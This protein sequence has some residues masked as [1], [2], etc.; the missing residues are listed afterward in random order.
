MKEDFNQIFRT[1][2]D[3]GKRLLM[4]N[5]RIPAFVL[6]V[7]FSQLMVLSVL[8]QVDESRTVKGKIT[9]NAGEPLPGVTVIVPE[10]TIGAVSDA[11]GI[12]L[13][14]VPSTTTQLAF[15]FIGMKTQIIN[16]T[17]QS[18][19]NV[20]MLDESIGLDEVVAVGYGTVSRKNL[21]TAISKV[22]TDEIVK[23][24]NSNMSQLLVGRASGLQATIQSAQPGGNVNLS[25]RGAGTPIYIVDGVMMP[26]GSLESGS[27]G[28]TTVI[29]SSVNRSGLAGLNPEDIESVEILKDASASIYGIGAAN[30]VILITTKKGKEG[31]LKVNYNG[32]F[33]RVE[34]AKYVHPLNAQDYMNFVNT[35]SKEQYL[36]NNAMAPYGSKVYDNKWNPAF[37]DSE[38]ANAQTTDW[39]NEVLRS[40]SIS[41]HNI[42]VTGGGEK[43]KY[44]TSGN[45][46]KQIGTVSNSQ[47]ERYSLRSQIDFQ[48]NSFINL[49][50]TVNVNRNFYLNSS[51]GGTSNG[52]GAQAS[53]AL[54][55]ALSY[56][57]Y[58]PV[59]N[60]NGEY[61]SFSYI[62]NA[63]A[64]EEIEDY[65]NSDG[66]YMN[67]VADFNLIKNVLKAKLLYGNNLENTKRSVYIPSYVYFDQMYKSRGNLAE[68]SRLNQTLE[69]TLAFNKSFKDFLT[70]NIVAGVGKYF[71]SGD[72]LNVAYDGQ[73]DAIAN[74]NL[75]AATGVKTPGSYRY[76]DEKRSQFIRADFDILD[77]YV[78]G[79]TVRRDGTDKFFPDSK[80]AI[81]PSI[82]F[83]WK[84]S[85]ESFLKNVAWIDLLKIRA[86][87]GTTGSDNLGTTLYGTY[88]PSSSQVM[89]NNNTIKY[90]PIVLNGLD[91]PD[92]SWQK[93]T[94]NNI[95]IDF[96]LFNNRVYG[97]FDLFQND[98]TDMLG[99]ANTAGLSM[100]GSY[101]IN[102]AHTR[103][104]GWDANI[105]V[106]VVQKADFTW[107]ALINLSR[108]NALWIERM[109]N[110]DY[111]DYEIQGRVPMNAQYYYETNGL[112]NLDM[113]NVPAS[114][115]ANARF[116]GF[117]VLVDQDGDNEITTGD[118]VMNNNVP[119]IYIGFGNTFTYK[120]FDLDIF[121]YSQQGV[122]KTNWAWSWASPT[123]LAN[124][125]NNSNEYAFDIWNSQ[126]NVNGK[127]PGI[128]YRLATVTL[129]GSAGTNLGNQD[130]SFVRVRN[131][132][133]GYNISG[134]KLGEVGKYINNIR[135]FVDAQNPILITNF[136]GF[137]PEVYSGG[138]YKG[139]KGEYPQIKT[140][141]AG[142]NVSF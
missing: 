16:I 87:Y 43:I 42:S 83:A 93:T 50:S 90:V 138:G 98:I 135:V 48:V 119:D 79:T 41:N 94:M 22:S 108:Y 76:A 13:I 6:I 67:F 58:I 106:K 71:N 27:G 51:V 142:V 19:I 139:G 20:T 61:S 141:S 37:S 115:P 73:H 45:Y 1:S 11:E 64:M 109:P 21:T 69:A 78:I 70:V 101:P 2:I 132:T 136:E 3:I 97:S 30:G 130:A 118:I 59:K 49:S 85:N 75:S 8:A 56:P 129:P 131:I 89:F 80:Y 7:I 82:S 126:T 100:F 44:Y 40:G 26:S 9:N 121:M 5:R 117:P 72:G 29:P 15:S 17:G 123:D 125:V 111:N 31:P 39:L 34:N 120:N 92:V 133:L 14:N 134:N 104:Q 124:Q 38:I 23:S 95:G 107:S 91:Y 47:M 46:F 4:F 63:V 53:G 137:D 112:I 62:P 127:F 55:A 84:I 60:E 35:F 74:D 18:N 68:D 77:R 10:T 28:T 65:T 12:Y 86:S 33:S 122:N 116:P 103:R 36:Y 105:N 32:S 25:I 102:G 99:T 57:S 128:A 66:T 88:S 52:R 81:F 24:S 110:Y 113:S 96:Y 140:F 54:T 114:Q